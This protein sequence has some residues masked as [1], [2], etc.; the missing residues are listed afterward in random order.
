M[1]DRCI[2]DKGV[3][4]GAGARVGDG[5]DNTPNQSTPEWLNTGLSVVGRLARIPTNAV[6]GRNA[7]IMP[8]VSESAFGADPTVKSGRTLGK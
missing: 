3:L 2:L 8:R 1:V 6:V 5:E 4:V 7:V